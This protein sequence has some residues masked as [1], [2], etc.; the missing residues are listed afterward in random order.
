M[1][2]VLD[3][4]KKGP[5]ARIFV[6]T[7][8]YTGKVDHEVAVSMQV[9]TMVCMVKAVILDWVGAGGFSL[10][11]YARNWLSMEF[12][13]RK[14]CTHILWLDDDVC[15][16]PD[17]IMK[18]LNRNVDAIGGC[19]MNKHPTKSTFLYQSLGPEVDGLQEASKLPGGFLLLT[20]QV[21]QTLADKAV[22]YE[23][24]HAGKTRSSPHIFELVMQDLPDGKKQLIGED[25]IFSQKVLQAG[26]KMYVE[27]N[28]GFT[29]FGRKGW[30][31]NLHQT[32]E[33]EAA[34]N[35][36]GQGVPESWKLNQ[37]QVEKGRA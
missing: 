15:F 6:A 14:E 21:M 26:F 33:R 31:G 35:V 18:L 1:A 30:S 8:C 36:G 29:H 17:A 5:R 7:P 23:L 2:S 24:E 34:A 22:W 37:E 25:Y 27:T 4:L 13:E 9:A 12:L 32:L 28:I 16:E 10:V 3:Q 19:Y 11:Q 20:H